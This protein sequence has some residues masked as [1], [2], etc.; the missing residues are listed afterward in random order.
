VALISD[1]EFDFVYIPNSVLVHKTIQQFTSLRIAFIRQ[2]SITIDGV[3]TALPQL[4][5][6]LRFCQSRKRLRSN[7]F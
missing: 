6:R 3:V 1:Q 2:L 4:V 5:C 7:S